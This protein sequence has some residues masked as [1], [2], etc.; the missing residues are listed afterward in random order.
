MQVPLTDRQAAVLAFVVNEYTQ[1]VRPVS[2][3]R[4]AANTKLGLS[5]ASFRIILSELEWL[6][7][8][9]HPHTSAGKIPTDKGYRYYVDYLMGIVD[10]YSS[11]DDNVCNIL[12]EK[13]SEDLFKEATRV[14]S[15]LT[16]YPSLVLPPKMG[17]LRCES[18]ELAYLGPNRF[19][20][21][22]L[23]DS[24][25]VHV[26]VVS[27]HGH[28]SREDVSEASEFLR[29]V[30]RGRHLA[31]LKEIL[32]IG[33]D[34]L[35]SEGLRQVVSAVLDKGLDC[36]ENR[37]LIWYGVPWLAQQPEFDAADLGEFLG[38]LEHGGSLLEL[39]EAVAAEQGFTI[40]IGQEL[41]P[42]PLCECSIVASSYGVGSRSLG[43][44]AIVGP[45]RMCYARA[46]TGVRALSR[47]LSA[48]LEG[49]EV[50]MG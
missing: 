30:C 6:G 25:V 31:S 42:G 9:S 43:A 27:L 3:A 26:K 46:V 22:I 12:Y 11:T 45:M 2:S 48:A 39:L 7:L 36:C 13:E 23:T 28:A 17:D 10:S 1:T 21:A 37:S 32:R 47:A 38:A 4:V 15:E 44:I 34:R 20:L 24:E 50:G 18:M 29:K 14:L 35:E 19:L 5:P 16:C 49:R 8:L 41:R 40:K 33:L